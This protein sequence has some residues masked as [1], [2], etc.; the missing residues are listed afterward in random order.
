MLLAIDTA[1]HATGVCLADG[2]QVLAEHIWHSG[3]Y[4]T[5]ELAPEVAVLLQRN[6]VDLSDLEAVAVASGPGSYTGLRIGMALAKGIAL[7]QRI[8][9]IGVPTLD[10]LAAAQPAADSPLLALIVAGR[11]RFAAVWYKWGAQGWKADSDPENWGWDELVSHLDQ[12]SIVCGELDA[13]QRTKLN[14]MSQ[15]TLASPAMSVR[16]PGFLAELAF[17]RLK[18]GKLPETAKLT[19]TYLGDVE[20]KA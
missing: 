16:R 13:S 3:R 9:L 4:H 6:H 19:P 7:A 2:A 8:P 15:V 17:K 10:I 20:S 1:T 14:K 12:P 5:V 18:A 11:G